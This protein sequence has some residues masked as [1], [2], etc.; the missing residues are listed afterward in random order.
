MPSEYKEISLPVVYISI[1]VPLYGNLNNIRHT[2]PPAEH[3]KL[4]DRDVVIAGK[5]DGG[6]EGHGLQRGPNGVCLMQCDAKLL[7]RHNDSAQQLKM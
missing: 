7:P 2:H 4:K 3:I 1:P 6:L 5:V